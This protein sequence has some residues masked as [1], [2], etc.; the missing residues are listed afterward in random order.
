MLKFP[1]FGNNPPVSAAAVVAPVQNAP[2]AA[3]APILDATAIVTEAFAARDAAISQASTVQ[4]ALLVE[5]DKVKSLTASAEEAK[6]K[7]SALEKERDEW[8]VKAET[9]REEVRTE[10]RNKELAALAASQG[11]AP[12]QVPVQTPETKSSDEQITEL[13][14]QI[15]A[16]KD[17]VKRGAIAGKINALR[18][19]A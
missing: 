14:A 7:I 18:W 9:P 5:Q 17:P 3:G 10:V 1:F 16:E 2:V 12:A 11:V 19:A 15:S 13:R 6:I 4:A 8:K